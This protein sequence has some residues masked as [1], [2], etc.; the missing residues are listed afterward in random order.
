MCGVAEPLSHAM[1]SIL[2]RSR[3]RTAANRSYAYFFHHAGQ[4]GAGPLYG[5]SNNAFRECPGNPCHAIAGQSAQ[6]MPAG[7]AAMMIPDRSSESRAS[8]S[9]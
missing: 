8:R 7:R 4:G 5:K 3:F 9:D 2:L 6:L 1:R